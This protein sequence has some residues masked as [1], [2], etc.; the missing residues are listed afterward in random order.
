VEAFS[1]LGIP[2]IPFPVEYGKFNC[3]TASEIGYDV[4]LNNN[5]HNG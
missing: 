2:R 5:I 4:V 1:N 3:L